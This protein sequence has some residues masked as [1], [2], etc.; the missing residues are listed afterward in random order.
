MKNP[1]RR[2]FLSF[3]GKY[4]ILGLGAVPVLSGLI[5]GCKSLEVISDV[6]ATA[7]EVAGYSDEANLI[8]KSGKSIART[9]QDFTPEQEY[10]LG[11]TVGAVILNKY[12]PYKNEKADKFINV[13]GQTMAKASDLPETFGGYHFLILDSNEINAL[14]APGGL[15][16]ITRGM[17]RCCNHE[18]AV[19]AVLAHEIGHVSLKHGLQAIKNSRI[20]SAFKITGIEATKTFGGEELA[21]LTKTFESAIS[22]VTSTLI[23][24]GY[25]R[26]FEREADQAAVTIMKRVGYNPSGLTDMLSVMDKKLK[27]GGMGFAKTHPSPVSRIADIKKIAGGYKK[28]RIPTARQ[29]RFMSFLRNV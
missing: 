19:A 8:R 27:P 15:I 10:Y 26:S 3:A 13:L 11:R 14:A 17:L 23:D 2:K 22:D 12:R 7:A 1:D 24:S 25:S 29:S 16:F 6:A 21:S 18:D 20:V 4:A 5:S 9:F 28:V